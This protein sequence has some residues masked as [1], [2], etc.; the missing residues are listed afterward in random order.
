MELVARFCWCAMLQMLN[1]SI[2]L[3]MALAA[4]LALRPMTR[5]L[6]EP[7]QRVA[8]WGVVWLSFC[9]PQWINLLDRVPLPFTLSSFLT[10]RTYCDSG[11]D[12][13]PMYLPEITGEGTYHLAPAWGLFHSHPGVLAGDGASGAAGSGLFCGDF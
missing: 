10:P 3:G 2:Y 12:H 11:F 7:R 1:W 9:L 13:F 5:R 8:L 6:L 4:L